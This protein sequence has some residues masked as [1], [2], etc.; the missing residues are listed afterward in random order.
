[1]Y[2]TGVRVTG[3]THAAGKGALGGLAGTYSDPP[4]LRVKN[5]NAELL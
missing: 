4:F 5:I 1:M 2:A 3:V